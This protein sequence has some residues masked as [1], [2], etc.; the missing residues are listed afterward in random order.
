MKWQMAVVVGAIPLAACV[1]TVILFFELSVYGSYTFYEHNS[2]IAVTEL[3]IAIIGMV[4][5][6]YLIIFYIEVRLKLQAR[7]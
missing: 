5:S 2:V 3:V 1:L 4:E 6:A 7:R